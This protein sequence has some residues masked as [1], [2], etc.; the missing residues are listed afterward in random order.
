[1]D[2]SRAQKLPP[3]A[4]YCHLVAA[5]PLRPFQPFHSFLAPRGHAGHTVISHWLWVI[6]PV[7]SFLT[8]Y[9]FLFPDSPIEV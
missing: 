7:S 2:R 5:K 8:D 6:G 4:I 9:G 3:T 1:M